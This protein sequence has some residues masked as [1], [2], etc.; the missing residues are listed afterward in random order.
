MGG[1]GGHSRINGGGLAFRK[2]KSQLAKEMTQEHK[3]K[4]A[5]ESEK[6][7]RQFIQQANDKK[8]GIKVS[9]DGDIRVSKEVADKADKLAK[10][11]A[12]RIEFT[13]K[14]AEKLYKD[15]KSR[16]RKKYY[17]APE[18]IKEI[19]EWRKYQKNSA[20]KV[21]SSRVAVDPD[22]SNRMINVTPI[23]SL[24]SSLYNDGANSWGLTNPNGA[25]AKLIELNNTLRSLRSQ[26]KYDIYSEKGRAEMFGASPQEVIRG[27]RGQLIENAAIAQV[28]YKDT[29]AKR[30]GG[31]KK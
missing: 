21:V 31:K 12:D 7:I 5:R 19:D 14:E 10:K 24:Y 9:E 25:A 20:I 18:D 3:L 2:E 22:N 13:D 17:I 27:I 6:E 26:I 16:V 28:L 23:D 1:H 11:L 30:S 29:R 15:F 8:D 4:Y